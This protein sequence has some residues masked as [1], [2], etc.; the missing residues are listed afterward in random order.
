VTW[1]LLSV[2]IGVS[3]MWLGSMGYSLF[4]AQPR[5]ARLVGHDP[6]RIEEIH[7]ELAHG[8]RWRVVVLI[9]T[10]WVTGAALAVLRPGGWIPL[11]V[12]GSA[13]A[14]AS[15][16]FWWV[17]WRAWPRRVF[18]LPEELP[19]LQLRFRRVALTMFALVALAFVAGLTRITI[20]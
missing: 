11:V 16:L 1:I 17:S 3:A 2:H 6:V 15:V 13:L 14:A 9:A 18:A 10:L 4:V 5:L 20:R 12:K 19:R 7:R 8:N